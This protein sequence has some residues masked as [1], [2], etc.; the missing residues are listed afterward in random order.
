MK[1]EEGGQSD[2]EGRNGDGGEGEKREV[3]RWRDKCGG[4][5]G[6]RREEKEKEGRM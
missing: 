6:E 1:S 4:A 3:K 5:K 2:G